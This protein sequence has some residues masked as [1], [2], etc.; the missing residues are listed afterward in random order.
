MTQRVCFVQRSPKCNALQTESAGPQWE[1]VASGITPPLPEARGNRPISNVPP[2]ESHGSMSAP[3]LQLQIP[4][5]GTPHDAALQCLGHPLAAGTPTWTKQ[6][7]EQLTHTMPHSS[8]SVTRK[9][10]GR[11]PHYPQGSSPSPVA[12]NSSR[13][14][15]LDEA[16][17]RAVHPHNAALQRFGDP[18][19]ALQ[20]LGDDPA[21]KPKLRVVGQRDGLGLALKL[22]DGKD[23]RR[24]VKGLG[25]VQPSRC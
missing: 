11:S 9:P 2:R 8:A 24:A 12:P 16:G 7:C 10:Y 3:P 4:T 17:L 23:L 1:E 22:N 15:H 25:Q 6:G 14:T 13:H 19:A 21:A 5:A 20:V 18:L